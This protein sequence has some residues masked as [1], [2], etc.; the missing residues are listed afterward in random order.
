MTHATPC[1]DGPDVVM[2]IQ[3][4]THH[5]SLLCRI[6]SDDR[7]HPPC[8]GTCDGHGSGHLCHEACQCWCHESKAEV[9]HSVA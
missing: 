1:C 7:S 8:S 2:R 4:P 6:L 9:D 3:Q 5:L